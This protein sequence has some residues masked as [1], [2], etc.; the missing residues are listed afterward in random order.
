[1]KNYHGIIEPQHLIDPRRMAVLREQHAELKKELLL[2]NQAWMKNG[3]LVQWFV[4]AICE[5]FKTSGQMGKHRL[6]GDSENNFEGPVIP[7]GSMVEYYLISA[8]DQ[9]RL[10]HHGKKVLPGFFIGCAS[11]LEENL[12]R[13]YFGRRH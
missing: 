3:G 11:N 8:R 10:H 2:C 1:M 5:V 12:E 13:T 4:A 9:L 7:F 6:K